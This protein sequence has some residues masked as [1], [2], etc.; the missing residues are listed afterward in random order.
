MKTFKIFLGVGVV[1]LGLHVALAEVKTDLPKVSL[2]VDVGD[3]STMPNVEF[4]ATGGA[5]SDES[6]TTCAMTPGGPSMTPT[7][8]EEQEPVIPPQPPITD[9]SADPTSSSLAPLNS[10]NSQPTY[11]G[12]RVPYVLP[13]SDTPTEP[14]DPPMLVPEP[15]TLLL[16]GLGVGAVFAARRRGKK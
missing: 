14:D 16:V 15:A 7:L 6:Q 13:P 2:S 10:L 1:L 9:V 3:G 12:N 11:T 8:L 4:S 5:G